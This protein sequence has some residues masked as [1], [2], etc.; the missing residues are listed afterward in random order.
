MGGFF[1]AERYA[2]RVQRRQNFGKVALGAL[3]M[4]PGIGAAIPGGVNMSGMGDYNI[5]YNSIMNGGDGSTETDYV[6]ALSNGGTRGSVRVSH[7]EYI[8]DVSSTT[9]FLNLPFAINPAN[10]SCFP[11]LATLARNFQEYQ[12]HGMVFHYVSQS[13]DALNS[14]N[15]ALGSVVMSTDYNSGNAPYAS[16]QAAENAEYTVSCKPSCSLVHGIEC[17]PAMTV[18]QGHLYISPFSDGTVPTGQDIK[19]YNLANFQFMTQGSQASAT[20]GELWVSYDISLIKPIDNGQLNQSAADHFALDTLGQSTGTTYNFGSKTPVKLLSGVGTTITHVAGDNTITFPQSSIGG[21]VY[22]V[23]YNCTGSATTGSAALGTVTVNSGAEFLDV[24]T[25]TGTA[26]HTAAGNGAGVATQMSLF[27]I[28]RIT[29]AATL[30]SP[31]IITFGSTSQNLPN[32]GNGDLIIAQL[33]SLFG[34]LPP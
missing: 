3:R 25:T 28:V 12:I 31:A 24:L 1:G 14:T 34:V 2:R 10:S 19:F 30:T 29:S 33:P 17:D 8:R 23:S 11:W 27:C 7:R 15:T 13:S 22:M 32:N 9:G 5:R 26:S 6:P 20:I 18:N 4:F 21:T 16:K